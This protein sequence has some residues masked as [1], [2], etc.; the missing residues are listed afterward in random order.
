[1]DKRIPKGA[2]ILLDFIGKTEAP[3]GY[4]TIYGNNQHRLKYRITELTLA[5][6]RKAQ[7]LFTKY[8]GSSASGRYQIMA[9]TLDAPKTLGDLMGELGL[10]G[11]EIFNSDMQDWLA[12]HLLKRR[13]YVQWMQG[14]ITDQQFALRLAMEWASFPVLAA[15]KG[16]HRN[17]KRGQS[18]YAGD[19][20]NK[21]LVKP[22]Q[23]EKLLETAKAG[24]RQMTTVEKVAV[25][26]GGGVA[27]GGGAVVAV[28]PDVITGGSEAV[29]EGAKDAGTVLDQ[30]TPITDTVSQLGYYGAWVAGTVVGLIVVAAVGIALYKWAKR[31]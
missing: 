5:Q 2:A 1:M 11:T 12:F 28:E 30:V 17:L 21:A 20:V 15:C 8:F 3:K 14:Q 7:P 10:Q 4:D 27:A 13:G 22:E 29:V 6:L 24:K 23:I 31:D 26:V 19:G 16:A 9:N 18:Y 25:G